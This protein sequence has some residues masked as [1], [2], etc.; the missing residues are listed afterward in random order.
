[1]AGY[2]K[3]TVE[4]TDLKTGDRSTLALSWAPDMIGAFP[5]FS[6]MEAAKKFMGTANVE[7]WE[8][9]VEVPTRQ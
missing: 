4:I 7:I 3:E 2:L 5:V 8:V 1:M 6:S 9:N